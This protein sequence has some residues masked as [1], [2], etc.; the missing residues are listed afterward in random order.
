MS[1]PQRISVLGATGS[2]GLSTL[3]VV[4]RHPDRYEAFALTGFSRLAEL[5]ALCLRHRPVYAVVPEQAAAIALQGSLAAAGIRTRVLFGEQALCEVASAPEV[6]M[7]MAAIVGAAGLPSTLAAVEAGKRVLLAN[8]EALVMSG[9]L[10]M[11]AVKRSGAVLLPIDS[12][13]NAIFQCMPGDYA[14]GLGAVGVRRI[15]LTAS[16]GPFRET[17]AEALL[18]VTP[19]QACAHPNWSMGRKIS[20]DSA[21]MLNKGLELIEACWLFD[22]RPSQIEVVVHPQSVIHSLVDYVDGSVLAQLGNPDMRTPISNALAWPERIDSGVAPLDLFAIAR[23]DFQAPDE[24]R[25]PCLRLARQAA[26]AGNSAPA[27]LNAANEVA[28][29]A[30]LQRRIRFPEIA[31]MIEQVLGQEPVVALPTL[32]AVFAADQRARELSREWLRRHGR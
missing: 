27:V 22:A 32:E 5:E 30:F 29:E 21:S 20:V 23:L 10:F 24:Q 12:E 28:V 18:D 17:P 7:V 26:E 25:F 2:I 19:E 4:Q 16:G 1:R 8:K 11:Q 3:D 6:D 14:R 15:L 31:G 9:A 13:H